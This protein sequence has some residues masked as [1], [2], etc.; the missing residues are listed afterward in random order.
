MTIESDEE[1]SRLIATDGIGGQRDE[2]TRHDRL[3][4]Y[5]FL[6]AIGGLSR[7]G[8]CG[9][10]RW[11]SFVSP[12]LPGYGEADAVVGGSRC[13][14]LRWT[15]CA[16]DRVRVPLFLVGHVEGNNVDL[17]AQESRPAFIG[18]RGESLHAHE[19]SLLALR[20]APT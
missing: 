18:A 6:T 15:C 9:D 3:I 1:F 2:Y 19:G 4:V 5:G 14:A 10:A 20:P 16:S 13:G 7:A 8:P 11:P 17:A 12:A